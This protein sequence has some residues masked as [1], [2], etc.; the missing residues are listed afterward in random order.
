MGL[1]QEERLQ[2]VV[3]ETWRLILHGEWWR[4]RYG[5]LAEF[6]TKFGMSES[7]KES[8]GGRM[9]TEK[10]KRKFEKW[11]SERL[12]GGELK[13]RLGEE[14]MPARLSKCFLEAINALAKQ[15]EDAED[16]KELLSRARDGRLGVGGA[17]ND[18]KIRVADVKAVMREVMGRSDLR[19]WRQKRKMDR[20]R[21]QS[22]SWS[23]GRSQSWR[24][25]WQSGNGAV[26]AQREGQRRW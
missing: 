22:Q 21:G 13:E 9:R 14:L 18:E 4:V 8:V 23:Q 7:V 16:A 2:E 6:M 5:S 10:L 11:A 24:T 12:G 19:S 1:E 25:R 17:S 26:N 15:V 20:S 3:A